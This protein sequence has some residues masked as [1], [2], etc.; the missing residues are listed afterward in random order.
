MGQRRPNVDA[1]DRYT[2]GHSAVGVMFGLWG[3]PWFVALGTSVVFEVL[4][5]CLLKPTLPG[6][7]PVGRRDTLA[8]STVDTL[9]WMAGWGVGRAI[10]HP[11]NEIPAIWRKPT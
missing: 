10:P 2:L 6:L 9:A 7:F 5:N 3:A 1:F 11:K 8:N 4:E